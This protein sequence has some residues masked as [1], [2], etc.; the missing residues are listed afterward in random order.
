MRMKEITFFPPFWRTLF[1]GICF[2]LLGLGVFLMLANS[3]FKKARDWVELH[4][5]K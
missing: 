5:D 2:V 3:S 4:R 1:L